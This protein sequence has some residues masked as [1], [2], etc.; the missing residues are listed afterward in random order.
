MKKIK[1]LF[2]YPNST[3]LGV[4]PV[5]LALLSSHLKKAGYKTKLFDASIYQTVKIKQDDLR[6]KLNQ[7][8]KTTIDDYI[9]IKNEDVV[10]AFAK[11]V[12]K[13]KPDL[14]AMTLVDSTVGLGF[15]LLSRVQDFPALKIIGGVAVTFNYEKL[16][17]ESFVD[18]ACIG[19]GEKAIVELCKKLSQKKDYHHIKNLY[20]KNPDGTT[21]KNPLRPL[22]DI[23][24]SPF[25]DF[26]IF[27]DFRFYR[28]FHG[29][30]VR[31][32]IIDTDRG[33]PYTCTYCAAPSLRKTFNDYKLGCYFRTKKIDNIIKEIRYVV[34]KYKVNFL[35]FSSETFFARSEAEMKDFATK[36]KKYVNLPFW[37]QTRLDTFT[38][39][40]TK[41]LSEMGCQAVS[42]GLEHGNE[43]FRE[44]VL[45][46]FISND[47]ILK[48][49]KLMA[50]YN[51]AA[52]VNNMLGFPDET[53][54]LIF[55]TINFNRK[56]Y[57]LLNK[58]SNLNVFIF[59]PFSG[60]PL[61]DICLEKGYVKDSE[62][63]SFMYTDS[64]LDMPQLHKDEIDGLARTMILYIKLPKKYWPKIKIAEK[65]NSAGNQAFQELSQVIA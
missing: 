9:K 63:T 36:Y 65:N 28:P 38:E 32:A 34:K 41:L 56:I 1:V 22:A 11:T 20:F 30:V 53:R 6:V 35:W 43:K 12:E 60:T 4:I 45:K 5:N 40:K 46:K 49:I 55:D 15:K 52:T 10:E 8:K 17:N 29:R 39:T 42:L 62:S 18:I 21:L 33:C 19:E 24:K 51:I 16:L 59:T 13:Y 26:S 64:V 14:I 27:E 54:K 50:K 47:R 44:S 37:C 48:S 57:P 31:M 25:P 58:E 7:V 23:N 3:L 2:A 61:R